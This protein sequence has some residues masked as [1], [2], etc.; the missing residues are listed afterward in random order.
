MT[1]KPFGC[2]DLLLPSLLAEKIDEP[3]SQ[4]R[5]Y[6]GC[7]Y[8]P[9]SVLHEEVHVMERSGAGFDHLEAGKPR[10]PVDIVPGKVGFQRP[11]LFG[12]PLLQGHVIGVASEQG[13]GS[14]G[15]G[16][17]KTGEENPAFS[18]DDGVRLAPEGPAGIRSCGDDESLPADADVNRSPFCLSSPDQE[19]AL[20]NGELFRWSCRHASP[21]MIRF[22]MSPVRSLHSSDRFRRCS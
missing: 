19:R 8:R 4:H 21:A 18:F 22:T 11:D 6:P 5:P 12:E 1:D 20:L 9:G 14:M 3:I 7:F 16:I 17:D 15:M 2:P 13:H 10:S